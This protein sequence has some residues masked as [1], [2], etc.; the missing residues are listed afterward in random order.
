[1]NNY[2]TTVVSEYLKENIDIIDNNVIL[3]LFKNNNFS[4]N[5]SLSKEVFP[6]IKNKLNNEEIKVL[7]KILSSH[8][9]KDMSVYW[10]NL[11]TNSFEVTSILEQGLEFKEYKDKIEFN[12][13]YSEKELLFILDYFINK[14]YGTKFY[15]ID[16]I[17]SKIKSPIKNKETI[18]KLFD[19]MK[20]SKSSIGNMNKNE[21]IEFI[22]GSDIFNSNIFNNIL[23]EE[24]KYYQYKKHLLNCETGYKNDLVEE[25][26]FE[27]IST[28]KVVDNKVIEIDV[29]DLKEKNLDGIKDLKDFKQLT[30]K[31]K[32]EIESSFYNTHNTQMFKKYKNTNLKLRILVDDEENILNTMIGYSPNK[33]E[34]DELK[35]YYKKFN[36]D[37][38]EQEKVFIDLTEELIDYIEESTRTSK[39]YTKDVND[40]TYS[41]K[42]Y[43]N[44]MMNYDEKIYKMYSMKK[45]ILSDINQ[46]NRLPR[47]NIKEQTDLN[48]RWKYTSSNDTVYDYQKI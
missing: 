47:K 14:G 32:K 48:L 35:K 17:I 2:S 39:E 34:I 23:K 24:N 19:Y 30:K 28:G 12:E 8:E 33:T 25:S 4:I 15:L 26:L 18:K 46:E 11:F 6:V 1:M 13:E 21:K 43:S 44:F 20:L 3:D 40:L 27:D 36:D 37:V 9:N 29:K 22:N 10:N 16:E 41:S 45:E 7:K 5:D 42:N 31:M 38:K